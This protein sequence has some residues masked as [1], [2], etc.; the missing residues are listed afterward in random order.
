VRHLAW[1]GRAVSLSLANVVAVL[2][3]RGI[4]TAVTVGHGHGTTYS[5]M[6]SMPVTHEITLYDTVELTAGLSILDDSELFLV[7][8]PRS[9]R[10]SPGRT[11]T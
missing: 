6:R 11:T 4:G 2:E 1:K 9:P 7:H 3:P 5:N 10:T 8:A